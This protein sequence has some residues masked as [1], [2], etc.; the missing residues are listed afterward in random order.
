MIH[1]RLGIPQLIP[2]RRELRKNQTKAEQILWKKLRS[3]QFAGFKFRRQH[4]IGPYIVDFCSP[5]NSIVVEVDGDIHDL[6]DQTIID[7]M[8]QQEIESLGFKIIRYHNKEI[9]ENLAP[10]LKDLLSKMS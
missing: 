8:R 5:S 6:P 1:L 4:G 9:L 2:R 7:R 10:T 3:K